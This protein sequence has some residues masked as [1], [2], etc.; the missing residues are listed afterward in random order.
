MPILTETTAFLR[1]TA[2]RHEVQFG[3]L[4]GKSKN[5]AVKEFA[6]NMVH[7]HTATNDR[8][9][10]LAEA[11]KIPLPAGLDS[12]HKQK[13]ARLEKLT[14]ADFDLAYISGQISTIKDS[15][16]SRMGDRFRPGCRHPALC[17]GRLA[18]GA[19]ASADDARHQG[20]AGEPIAR[21]RRFMPDYEIMFVRSILR[22]EQSS[23]L[24]V[25]MPPNK[26]T[27]DV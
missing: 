12:D 8:L 27:S 25:W 13:H 24:V 3:E 22:P 6:R 15:A 17:L 19:G 23:S 5:A 4:A 26:E 18:D 10:S 7:D 21:R 1:L 2:K 9:K 11:S 14:G 20:E 16:A